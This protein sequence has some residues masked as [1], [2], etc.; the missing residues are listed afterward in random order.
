[1]LE[2]RGDLWSYHDAGAQWTVVTTNGIVLRNGEAVTGA[3]CA[4][5]ATHRYP[6]W[7]WELGHD[8][9][10]K[11]NHV[12]V[13]SKYRLVS[14]PTKNDWRDDSDLDLIEAS[15][16]ELM[17][18]LEPYNS[19]LVYLPRPGCGRGRLRWSEVQPVIEPILDDRVVIVTFDSS[20]T[21][22]RRNA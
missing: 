11:G 1:M 14:F 17:A 9:T 13:F 21:Q 20:K 5:E 22:R 8:L 6:E 18:T 12:H 2:A 7:P 10:T 3:G 4:L 16:R 19:P 15:C